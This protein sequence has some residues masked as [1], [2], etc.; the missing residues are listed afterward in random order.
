MKCIR[1]QHDSKYKERTNKR[2]PNCGGHFAFEPRTGDPLTDRAFQVAIEAVSANGKVRWGVEHLYYEVCRRKRIS[3]STF[4][5]FGALEL[6][7]ATA[8]VVL[9]LRVHPRW[10]LGLAGAA[11]AAVITIALKRGSGFARMDPTT[12]SRL[13][14][15]WCLAHGTPASVIV[16]KEKPAKPRKVEPDLADYSFDRAVI[17]DRAR[18]VDLLLANNFHFENNCA[19]LSSEGYPPGPFETVR[20]MLQR[21]PKLQVF[22]LHDATPDGCRLAHKLA[23]DPG[24]F[25]GRVKVIDVGLRPSQ[26][27]RFQGL[28]LQSKGAAVAAGEGI[29]AFEAAWLSKYILELAAIRPEQVLKRLFRT[30]NLPIKPEQYPQDVIYLPARDERKVRGSDGNGSGGGDAG[31]I[32]DAAGDADGPA[33]AFG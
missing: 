8:C 5:F 10:W 6:G 28:L 7:V 33:D 12:F 4:V 31:M 21:N 13:W 17:C 24:W 22:A 16:R 2:C 26:A 29:T 11:V 20:K 27:A 23:T 30:L 19:V 3:P 15:S 1:C 32:S 18:T 25:G 9:A 14:D